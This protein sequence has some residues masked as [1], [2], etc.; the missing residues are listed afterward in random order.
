[1]KTVTITRHSKGIQA[2][3]DQARDEDILL[4]SPDGTEFFLAAIDDFGEEIARTRR[5]KKL[6]AF[7]Q[8]RARGTVRI[9][10]SEVNR[11][12]GLD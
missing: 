12:L 1:M 5:N 3:L 10:S 2:L 8:A 7:L 9:P 6:K 4:V 11:R